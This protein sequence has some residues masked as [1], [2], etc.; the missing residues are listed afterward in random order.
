MDS[1]QTVKLYR[2]KSEFVVLF[3]NL[4]KG[5]ALTGPDAFRGPGGRKA[6]TSAEESKKKDGFI[7]KLVKAGFLSEEDSGIGFKGK[8]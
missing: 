6:I 1:K 8:P 7:A 3:S 4:A 2:L 5:K